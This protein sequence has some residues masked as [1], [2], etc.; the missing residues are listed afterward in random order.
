MASALN[1]GYTNNINVVQVR[2]CGSS[3]QR[4]TDR[5]ID[6]DSDGD[7]ESVVITHISGHAAGTA[8]APGGKVRETFTVPAGFARTV[9]ET[10]RETDGGIHLDTNVAEFT[11]GF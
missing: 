8:S 1:A 3:M 11:K 4:L 7:K 10:L 5:S 6:I 2:T 9:V